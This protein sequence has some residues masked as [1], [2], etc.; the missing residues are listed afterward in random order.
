MKVP[1]Y[2][3]PVGQLSEGIEVSSEP[4][5]VLTRDG[6]PKTSQ[7]FPGQAWKIGVKYVLSERETTRNGMTV[8]DRETRDGSVTVWARVKPLVS[9]GD[10]VTFESVMTGAFSPQDGNAAVQFVQATDIKEA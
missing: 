9:E 1:S 3:L 2:L 5:E 6:E 4:Q 8:V 10:V 7:V